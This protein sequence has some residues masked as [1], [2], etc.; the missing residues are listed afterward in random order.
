MISNVCVDALIAELS[1][2]AAAA[3]TGARIFESE[4][5][6]HTHIASAKAYRHAIALVIKHQRLS[7]TQTEV[8]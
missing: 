2:H 7:Q 6:S 4:S 3:D 5:K 8:A 1:R